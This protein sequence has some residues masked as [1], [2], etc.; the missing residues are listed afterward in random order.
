MK[1]QIFSVNTIDFPLLVPQK[2]F[3]ES[4]INDE[5]HLKSTFNDLVYKI[6]ESEAIAQQTSAVVSVRMLWTALNAL[7]EPG[8]LLELVLTIFKFLFFLLLLRAPLGKNFGIT[9]YLYLWTSTSLYKILYLQYPAT[10]F[11]G[12]FQI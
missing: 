12:I 5:V 1:N 4:S 6:Q 2:L 7:T 10:N 9:I 11:N 8:V 3:V